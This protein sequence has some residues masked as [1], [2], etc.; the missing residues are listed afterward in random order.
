MIKIQIAA[1][2]VKVGDIVHKMTKTFSFIVSAVHHIIGNTGKNKSVRYHSFFNIVTLFS[3]LKTD[4]P[5]KTFEYR[6]YNI[7]VFIIENFECYLFK[8]EHKCIYS[9][10][11]KKIHIFFTHKFR[12]QCTGFP[13]SELMSCSKSFIY[14]GYKFFYRINLFSRNYIKS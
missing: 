14:T 10:K 4:A 5:E 7:T 2:Y 13:E 12:Y 1:F 11:R 8:A 9:I 3:K 6:K